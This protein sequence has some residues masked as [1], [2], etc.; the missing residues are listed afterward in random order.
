[1][2]TKNK[3]KKVEFRNPKTQ[4][5]YELF[6]DYKKKN[7]YHKAFDPNHWLRT[8]FRLY[9]DGSYTYPHGE[10][11]YDHY[12][13]NCRFIYELK[14]K[15]GGTKSPSAQKKL[16]SRVISEFTGAMKVEFEINHNA[17][18]KAMKA[19]LTEKQIETFNKRLIGDFLD[20]VD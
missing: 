16:R 6:L 3:K 20:L 1:M 9:I 12:D 13:K 18:F 5:L 15:K 4:E 10:Q 14:S 19:A 11:G 2:A 8:T 7:S 17:I